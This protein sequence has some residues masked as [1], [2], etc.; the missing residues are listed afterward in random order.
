M[1]TLLELTGDQYG[2]S[3][4]DD[5]ERSTKSQGRGKQGLDHILFAIIFLHFTTCVPFERIPIIIGTHTNLHLHVNSLKLLFIFYVFLKNNQDRLI[6]IQAN[7][8]S[9]LF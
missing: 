4:V 7:Q 9:L 2:W 1:K 5:K 8:L 6:K 3:I